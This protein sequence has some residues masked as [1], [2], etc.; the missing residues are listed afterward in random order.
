[1]RMEKPKGSHFLLLKV[2]YLLKK[3]SFHNDQILR[4]IYRLQCILQLVVITLVHPKPT[5]GFRL[6]SAN[7]TVPDKEVGK[8]LALNVLL[9]LHLAMA[10][11]TTTGAF[12][13]TLCSNNILQQAFEASHK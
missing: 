9:H 11:E 10:V 8:V 6:R 7:I 2:R 4:F 5:L 1:M 12:E 3:N 13:P